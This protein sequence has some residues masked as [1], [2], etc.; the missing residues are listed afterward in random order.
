VYVAVTTADWNGHDSDAV[1]AAVRH[2]AV[3]V[4]AERL[5]PV[6]VPLCLVPDSR[7]ALGVICQELAGRPAQH[8]RTIGVTGTNG[9]TTTSLLI[10]S[11]LRS[12]KQVTGV[13]S[14]LGYHDGYDHAAAQRTTPEAL[15]LAEWL[16]RMVDNRCTNAVLELSSQALAEKRAA[17]ID[18]DVAVLTN[19]RRDHLDYHGSVKTYRRLKASLLRQLR[20]AG[21]AVLNADDLTS[22]KMLPDLDCP[23]LTFGLHTPA[24]V[25]ASVVERRAGEQVFLLAAGKETAAVC[26]RMFGDHHVYNCL[27]AAAVGLG[28]G[29]DLTMIARGVEALTRVPGRLEPIVCGQ[30][31]GV[32]VDYARSPDALAVTLKAL[33]QVTSGRVI[34]VFGADADRDPAERPLLGRVVERHAHRGIITNNNPRWEE[35]LQIAHDILDGY[36]RPARAHLL[37]DRAEAIRW[38]LGEARPGDAVLLAGKGDQQVQVVRDEARFF[39]DGQVAQQWLQ[40]AGATIDYA[41][42]TRQ[43]LPFPGRA[44]SASVN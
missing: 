19:V 2:G 10:A 35:P 34:C 17:G 9:K 44:A 28:L 23:V 1:A 33:R 12:A 32:Y 21:F 24:E 8:L 22:R 3:A 36:E 40:E 14:T 41:E 31:F 43:I 26:T 30:P 16:T 7:E 29:L 39:D 18:Y 5:L 42:S 4:V 15:E 20:P 6:E 27:A 37:T 11:I 13:T 38:A 25:T